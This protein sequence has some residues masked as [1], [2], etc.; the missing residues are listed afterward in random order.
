VNTTFMATGVVL[1]DT[2]RAGIIY[3]GVVGGKAAPSGEL[4]GEPFITVYCL[5]PAHGAP[6]GQATAPANTSPE[7]TF[8]ELSVLDEGGVLYMRRTDKGITMM[9]LD[10]RGP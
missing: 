5:E 6:I 8:R 10:C 2:D 3:L 9:P 7:E 4:E 1:L